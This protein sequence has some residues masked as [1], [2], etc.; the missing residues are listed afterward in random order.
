MFRRR[1]SGFTISV[2]IAAGALPSSSKAQ[3][4]L[5]TGPFQNFATLHVKPA[6]LD[7]FLTAMRANA[8]DARAGDGNIAFDVYAPVT[9]EATIYVFEQW[10][11]QAAYETHLKRPALLAMH[12]LASRALDG[13]ISSLLLVAAMPGSGVKPKSVLNPA[14]TVNVLSILTA[15]PHKRGSVI[16]Q[17]TPLLA[18][19]RKAP[20]DISVDL[21]K[22]IS[23]PDVL[24]Q[25]QR[26]T[27]AASYDASLKR[28]AVAK[29][30]MDFSTALAKPMEE[31]T[32]AV[33]DITVP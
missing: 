19:L 16:K 21:Y 20:G 11:D 2:A 31:S 24:V 32:V 6:E 15:K 1:V 12:Q 22:S 29:M 10:R 14:T 5:A 8:A 30:K 17:V 9:G 27:N 18:G 23:E 7:H 33:K 13:K 28:S 25:V 3:A 26:W 4:V